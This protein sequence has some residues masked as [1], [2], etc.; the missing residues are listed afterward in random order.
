M[1]TLDDLTKKGWEILG[2]FV[3]DD[4]ILVLDKENGERMMYNLR[5]GASLC[6]YVV[7]K[8]QR[9]IVYWNSISLEK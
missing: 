4:N 6:V 7:P 5:Q 9:D 3:R 2:T 1:E 8:E